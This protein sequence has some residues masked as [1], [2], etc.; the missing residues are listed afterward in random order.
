MQNIKNIT[1]ILVALVLTGC[2]TSAPQAVFTQEIDSSSKVHANDQAK[3]KVD[4]ALD[5]TLLNYE[6]ERLVESIQSKLDSKKTWNAATGRGKQY[7]VLVTI[8][9]YEKGSPVARMVS[10][11]LGQIHIN[12]A[13]Q[14]FALPLRE[15]TGEFTLNKTFAWGGIYGA[16]TT[17]EDAEQGFAEGVADALT[18]QSEAP[19]PSVNSPRGQ[20]R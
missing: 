5:V 1:I 6:K 10:A 14:I 7:E 9:R 17:I 19:P 8:T 20:N 3:V 13:V 11:G 2:A 12:G 15:K 16:S 4:A 18:G